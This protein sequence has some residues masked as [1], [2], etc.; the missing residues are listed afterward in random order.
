MK[1]SIDETEW[2]EQE[3]LSA[4]NKI[5]EKL[6]EI[7]AQLNPETQAKIQTE[8]TTDPGMEMHGIQPSNV[9]S[10]GTQSDVQ[11][12]QSSNVNSFGNKLDVQS[13]QSSNVN[14]FGIKSDV[15]SD[16]TSSAEKGKKLRTET[17]SMKFPKP[18][19]LLINE[20]PDMVL[21]EPSL[22]KKLVQEVIKP[23][24]ESQMGKYLDQS[25]LFIKEQKK[26]RAKKAQEKVLP[27][28][29]HD[30]GRKLYFIKCS[31]Q[32]KN[33][34]VPFNALVDTGAANSLIHISVINNM[35]L[36]YKP[37][38]LTLATASGLDEDAIKGVIHLKFALKSE[39]GL[40]LLCCANFIVTTKL[41]GLQSIIGAEFLMDNENVRHISRSNLSVQIGK[42]V[43]S[44]PISEDIRNGLT[45]EPEPDGLIFRKDHVSIACKA[46]GNPKGIKQRDPTLSEPVQITHAMWNNIAPEIPL[47]GIQ[48]TICDNAYLGNTNCEL[49]KGI[50]R[51]AFADPF[52]NNPNSLE[53]IDLEEMA[54]YTHSFK[55]TIKDETLP[56]SEELFDETVELKFEVLDKLITLDEA[57]YSNCPAEWLKPLRSMLDDYQDRF[58]KKKLD[59]DI[60]DLYEAD[61]KTFPNRKVVQRV[62]TLPNHKFEFALKAIR[63]LESAGVIQESDSEWRSNVVMIPKPMGKN[64]LRANTK[65]DYQ[66]G[67]QHEAQHYRICLDFRDLNNILVFPKQVAFPTLEKFLYKLRNKIVVSVDISSSFYVIP[68]KEEDRYKTAFWVNDYAFEFKVLVMGLKSS[69]Y[70]LKKFL[71]LAYNRENYKIYSAKLSKKERELIPSSFEDILVN[72]FDDVFVIGD[73]YE[74]TIANFKLC[75]MIARLA[76]IKFSVEKSSFLT[77]KVK[78][79]GYEFDTKDVVLTMDRLKASAI[80]NLKKPSSL[81]ELHSRLASFQYNSMFI[82]FLKHISY[83]LHFL[84]RK[85]VF[86]W[87]EIEEQSWNMLK[88]VATLGLRL[89]VPEPN[90]NLVIATDASKIAASACLFRDRNGKL[91]LVAVNSKFFSAVDLNKCSYMLESIALAYGLKIFQSYILNCNASVK[92]FTDA[93]ALIYAKRNSTHSILLNSTLSYLQ[94]IVSLVNVELYHVPGT[95]NVLA[96]VMSRAIS[97]NLNCALP[98]EHPISKEWAKV[99]PPLTDNFGVSRNAL[100]EFLT[101][102][103]KPEPQDL[104][105]RRQRRL[106]EPKTVQDLFD[107]TKT[108]SDE[109]RYY[110]AIRLLEQWNDKYIKTET[111]QMYIATKGANTERKQNENNVKKSSVP[112]D[113]NKHSALGAVKQPF[114]TEQNNYSKM[115]AEKSSALT[116]PNRYREKLALLVNES[117]L[118]L[119]LIKKELCFKKLDEIMEKLYGNIKGSAV[120]KRI[121]ENLQEASKMYILAKEPPLTKDK[122]TAF[123]TS[124]EELY[125]SISALERQEVIMSAETEAIKLYCAKSSPILGAHETINLN[126]VYFNTANTGERECDVLYKHSAERPAVSISADSSIT[127]WLANKNT[128]THMCSLEGTKAP[129][130]EKYSRGNCNDV[131]TNIVTVPVIQY[132]MGPGLTH[133][134]SVS[135]DNNGLHLPVQENITIFPHETKKVNLG[136]RFTIPK[137]YTA[138]IKGRPF[139]KTKYGLS[140]STGLI[141]VGWTDC[142]VIIALNNTTDVVNIHAGENIAQLTLEKVNTPQIQKNRPCTALD[143]AENESVPFQLEKNTGLFNRIKRTVETIDPPNFQLDFLNINLLGDEFEKV[144]QLNELIDFEHKFISHGSVNMMANMPLMMTGALDPLNE[145]ENFSLADP[146]NFRDEN[147]N[148]PSLNQREM[149]ALLAADLT[150][151]YK[152]SVDTL[153]ELQNKEIRLQRIKEDLLGNP[154][155]HKYFCIKKGVLCR[156]YTITKTSVQQWGIYVPTS[157]LYAVVIYVHK[158]FMHPSKTQTYKEFENLYYHPFAKKAVQIVCEACVTCTQ[159]RNAETRKLHVG[160]ERTIKPVKPRESVSMDILYFPASAKGYNYGLIIADLYS[161]YIS[162]YPMKSKN[163]AEVAKN[164]RAYFSAHCPPTTVY[165]DNDTGFRGD[166]EN[167]FRVYGIQHHTSYPH[168]QRQNYVESQ[169]RIFKNAYRAAIIDSPVFKTRDWDTLYPLVVCRINSMISKYG[170][171]REAVHYGHIVESSLPLITD[172]TVFEPLEDDLEKISNLFRVRMGRFMQKRQRNKTYYKIGKQFNFYINELVMYK[173][174]TPEHMLSPTFIGPA[175]IVDLA[176]SGATLRDTK[177]GATFSVA[178]EN[179]RKVSF[180]E[181]LTLLPQNFDSEIADSIGNYRYRRASEPTVLD[182]DATAKEKPPVLA[183]HNSSQDKMTFEPEF[184]R[185]RSGKVFNVRLENVPAKLRKTVK[186]CTLRLVCVPKVPDPTAIPPLPCLYRRYNSQRLYYPYP[187]KGEE[188]G[189]CEISQFSQA[190]L[191]KVNRFKEK[192][193]SSTF[194]SGSKCRQDFILKTQAGS[195]RVKFGTVTVFYI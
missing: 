37:L 180:E 165:S 173:V 72:F 88:S 164:L 106:M 36:P 147:G 74:Q 16:Q 157:I 71:E 152:L 158:F 109:E 94:N 38:K 89:T 43:H 54:C 5:Q 64:E 166:T 30:L 122:I 169:I 101:N 60:T 59:L 177:T 76:K 85:G 63:Q 99:L 108:I 124:I 132:Q 148:C 42:T 162:F 159:S 135:P 97:D 57:D 171:S 111:S 190:S 53:L 195:N 14:S 12:Y 134:P 24:P 137:G 40:A 126:N 155:A 105:D 70:H 133:R 6:C 21:T 131:F 120:Y 4:I 187:D 9:N 80:Q 142:C 194:K 1:Q 46:C 174:Y 28:H 113:K 62:R 143:S 129:P 2:K 138:C 185:T 170:M 34:E 75:L 184:R 96:D 193:M 66:R 73:T 56:P 45:P 104:H 25:I 87:G 44:I 78:V 163:S 8:T 110:S 188:G 33:A 51:A 17:H 29:F 160:R 49:R 136:F 144:D 26:L 55:Q 39:K 189:E 65:A 130:S 146:D 11:S 154:D 79:L 140:I 175:R 141:E 23:E 123:N 178:F 10:F 27:V 150:D 83:P 19:T 117:R 102:T 182:P 139:I 116:E 156:E 22:M 100:F 50:E 176:E 112:N 69:P 7:S 95:I 31:T 168:T 48:E 161:L 119:D 149:S 192:P 84:L 77:T 20:Y 41:N 18:R 186:V 35:Q 179:M 47:S 91:E 61:L 90:E 103:L 3:C 107:L 127:N 32:G 125:S 93:K 183:R 67:D 68:I 114:F 92:I 167:L 82:P 151:N 181:V 172:A 191:E 128:H 118:E 86:K 81:F 153:V 13:Y 121:L 15:E 115:S 58:S 98:R 52:L 145:D